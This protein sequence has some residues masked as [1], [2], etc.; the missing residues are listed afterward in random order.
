MARPLI[1]NWHT[2]EASLWIANDETLYTLA[3]K[4]RK[5]TNPYNRFLYL[6]A[7]A[8]YDVVP[9]YSWRFSDKRIQRTFMNAFIRTIED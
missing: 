6:A 7:C 4:A 5:A 9:G 2:G 3:K 1:E 8:G